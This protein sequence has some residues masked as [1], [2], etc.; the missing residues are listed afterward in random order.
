MQNGILMQLNPNSW[1]QDFTFTFS[2]AAAASIVAAAS[3]SA[4]ALTLIKTIIPNPAYLTFT[5]AAN[6]STN[7]FTVVFYDVNDRLLTKTFAGPNATLYTLPV[8]VGQIVSISIANNSAGAISV[9]TAAAGYSPW[10]VWDRGRDYWQAE[11][12]V[13]LSS[14]ASATYSV[15]HCLGLNLANDNELIQNDSILTSQTSSGSTYLFNEN[16]QA[17]RV[18]VSAFTSG[19]IRMIT[20]A[21]AN[22][23]ASAKSTIFGE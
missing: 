14:G 20:S 12:G 11:I 22:N 2:N 3:Y 1:D 17:S 16:Y 15:Q 9:G 13:Q 8:C 23:R 19:M 7:T 10:I 6:E 21:A 18:L 4:G 5:A